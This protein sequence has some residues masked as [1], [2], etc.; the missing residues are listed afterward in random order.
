MNIDGGESPEGSKQTVAMGIT[1]P[2]FSGKGHC[3]EVTFEWR[4]AG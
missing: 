2:E 4:P 1:S 3:E